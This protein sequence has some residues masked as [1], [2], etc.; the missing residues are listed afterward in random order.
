MN[1]SINTQLDQLVKRF[2]K[3]ATAPKAKP[4][5]DAGEKK[6][7]VMLLRII[8][9]PQVVVGKEASLKNMPDAAECARALNELDD[10]ALNLECLHTLRQNA[11]PTPA[12]MKELEEARAAQPT[13]PFALPEQYM[14]TIGKLTAYQPRLD[15]WLF[16]RTYKEKADSYA[17]NLANFLSIANCFQESQQLT[18]IL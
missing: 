6:E 7:K 2:S 5:K 3:N 12:Q 1:D 18:S 17:E 14:W 8:T 11:C 16:V 10:Q 9:D 4:K 15:C 13:L